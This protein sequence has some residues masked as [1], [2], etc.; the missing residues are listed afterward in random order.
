MSLL[1]V[2][3]GLFLTSYFLFNKRETRYTNVYLGLLLLALVIRIGKSVFFYFDSGLNE[4][5]IL[6]GLLGCMA[7]GPM[8]LYFAKS[9]ING[10]KVFDPKSLLHLIPLLLLAFYAIF[11]VSYDEDRW[12]WR[13]QIVTGIYYYW[14]AYSLYAVFLVVRE[15][16]I[17]KKA[18]PEAGW[19]QG[20]LLGVT[21]I[22]LAYL[23]SSFT[24]YLTGALTF[25]FAVYLLAWI[26]ITGSRKQSKPNKAKSMPAATMPSH[27]VDRVSQK[28]KTVLLEDQRY[29][30]PELSMPVLAK[31]TGL[32]PHQFSSFIND[33]LN[34]N[35]SQLI[36]SYRIEAAREMLRSE[37]HLTVEAIG[38]DC[39]FNSPSTFHTAFKKATGLT[40]AAYR[41]KE[42][43]SANL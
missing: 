24:S 25:S 39:G 41:K 43:V 32:T 31:L 11:F 12:L 35:F 42:S 2:F 27:E 1:G 19:T 30:S 7:I 21:L 10:N 6:I 22:W 34:Q 18:F 15:L 20:V 28:I 38:F 14:G 23:T 8:S 33:Q 5:Y 9:Q 13:T 36:N 17:R 40:P 37:A 3:N 4:N 29:K 26:I 16:Y